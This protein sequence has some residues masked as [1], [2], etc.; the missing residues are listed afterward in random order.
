MTQLVYEY[1]SLCRGPWRSGCSFDY[2]GEPR[3]LCGGCLDNVAGIAAAQL[4]E[5]IAAIKENFP[6]FEE[7]RQKVSG[8]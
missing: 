6:F 5:E 1:C 4:P 3:R 8:G 7:F 2:Q